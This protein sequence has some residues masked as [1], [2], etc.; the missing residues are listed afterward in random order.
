MI[1]GECSQSVRAKTE[2]ESLRDFGLVNGAQ[3]WSRLRFTVYGL[4]FVVS[5]SY[6]Q[7][8]KLNQQNL[9]SA[10]GILRNN[11]EEIRTARRSQNVRAASFIGFIG[12]SL[13]K[14]Y[15]I[16]GNISKLKLVGGIHG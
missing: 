12:R 11:K 13:S 16:V 6:Q 2:S 10:F 8:T 5:K 3:Y 7:L 1:F 14:V 15:F 4:W 9:K